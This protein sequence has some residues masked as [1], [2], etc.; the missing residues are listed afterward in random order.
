MKEVEAPTDADLDL[1]V[2]PLHR[3]H[4]RPACEKCG[5]RVTLWD[6][7]RSGGTSASNWVYCKGS[8]DSTVEVTP[9]FQKTREVKVPCFGVFVEHLHLTC[10]RCNW[11]WLMATKGNKP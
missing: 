8:L 9:L 2:M 3:Y 11:S 5:L 4:P 6:A 10:N 1:T 7:I